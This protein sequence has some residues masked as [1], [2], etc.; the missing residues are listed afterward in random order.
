MLFQQ[1]KSGVEHP[2]DVNERTVKNRTQLSDIAA[3]RMGATIKEGP[4]KLSG[5]R[6]A[7]YGQRRASRGG[8][9]TAAP[10]WSDAGAHA[11]LEQLH[12]DS[13]SNGTNLT[14]QTLKV[15]TRGWKQFVQRLWLPL[16]ERTAVSSI[17][18]YHAA[19]IKQE[20]SPFKVKAM[21]R[22]IL[23][24]LNAR[25]AARSSTQPIKLSK[26]AMTPT[27]VNT[28]L[29]DRPE[30][31]RARDVSRSQRMLTGIARWPLTWLD[32]PGIVCYERAHGRIR[33]EGGG[34]ASEALVRSVVKVDI[35]PTAVAQSSD[36]YV[37]LEPGKPLRW[38]TVP[39]IARCFWVQQS[40]PLMTM[41]A[42]KALTP[43]QAASALGR[44]VHAGVA[45]RLV[46]TL[47]SRGILKK[48]LTYGS[49]FS[50][51]DTFAEG[52][53]VATAG[54]FK[55]EFGSE[56]NATIR[57]ALAT[58]WGPR[59]LLRGACHVDAAGAGATTAP[60]VDLYVTT[61]T[62][63]SCSRRNRHKSTGEQDRMLGTFWASL[64]YVRMRRPRVVI[65]E[66]V[67]EASAVGPIT[68]LLGRLKDY[69]M[70]S[71]PLDPTT[72]ARA[73]V[74]RTRHYWVLT[75]RDD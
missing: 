48:G 30:L 19:R 40:S 25:K 68:G 17:F 24:P 29:S 14:E 57:N 27:T 67:H 54:Q 22:S 4:R 8:A 49:A 34:I 64:E 66:N 41:L 3:K 72:T 73:S 63:E 7:R 55:Y 69:T 44:S 38:A 10:G 62:C 70:E 2:I 36:H 75:R 15:V 5:G 9:A 65:V 26:A 60:T 20:K 6:S 43:T 33:H 46:K 32:R 23:R 53:R 21:A 58:A 61:P 52:V 16:D 31:D 51:I 35:V 13:T 1:L 47:M 59:G 50:G 37:V 45:Y 12:M 74:W 39:E 56:I 18:E 42:G 71:D 11:V 28:I